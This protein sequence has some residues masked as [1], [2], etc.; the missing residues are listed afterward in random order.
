MDKEN[1]LNVAPSV[2]VGMKRNHGC[3]VTESEQNL[4]QFGDNKITP[5]A[6][7][8]K[9]KYESL[10]KNISEQVDILNSKV[11]ILQDKESKMLNYIK[12]LEQKNNINDSA[13]PTLLSSFTSV[14]DESKM[15]KL[16]NEVKCFKLLT[17]VSMDT[18]I[19]NKVICTVR[20]REK[21]RLVK[22]ELSS[23]L[24]DISQYTTKDELTY[25]PV[26]N[27]DSLPEYLQGEVAF[28]STL[29]P[30]M[31]GDILTCLYD[32]NA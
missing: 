13:I 3:L 6:S 5:D 23:E 32:E 22:F 10:D 1:T 16:R 11:N 30:A 18:N 29:A 15:L 19:D 31:M 14:A 9:E 20:N 26:A 12:L 24:D 4:S 17:G 27:S 2:N 8:W 28:G 7:F 21:K 25:K